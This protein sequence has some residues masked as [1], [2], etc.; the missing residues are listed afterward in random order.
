MESKNLCYCCLLFFFFFLSFSE[1]QKV[2][3]ALTFRSFDC[4]PIVFCWFFFILT[5]FLRESEATERV[6]NSNP[7]LDFCF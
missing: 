6:N 2:I 1:E 5:F 4:G 7:N 3:L